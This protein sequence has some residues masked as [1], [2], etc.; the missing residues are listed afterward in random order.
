MSCINE[1]NVVEEHHIDDTLNLTDDIVIG[2]K[3]RNPYSIE[4]MKEACDLMYPPTRGEPPV[5]DSLIVPNIKYVRFLP[6]DS[7]EYRILSN[8]GYELFNYPLD[9]DIL[10][11][12]SDYH[13]PNL[14]PEQI[15]WQY[16]VMPIE[17]PLPISNAEVLELGFL[18]DPTDNSNDLYDLEGIENTAN[19]LVLEEFTNGLRDGYGGGSSASNNS[20]SN[21]PRIAVFDHYSQSTKGVKGIKVRARHFLKIRTAYTD[22]LGYYSINLDGIGSYHPRYE[23]RFENKYGFKIG[24]GVQLIMPITANMEDQNRVTYIYSANYKFWASCIINNAAYDWYKRCE[25][26]GMPTPPND[27]YIWAMEMAGGAACPMFHHKTLQKSGLSIPAIVG[28]YFGFDNDMINFNLL[29]RILELVAP[30][31]VIFGVDESSVEELY[32]RTCHE[33]SHAT[34][35]QRVGSNVDERALWWCDVIQYEVACGIIDSP[36][37]AT[38]VPHSGKVGVTEMWAHAVGH[39][40]QYE[41]QNKNVGAFLYNYWFKPEVIL[42]LYGSGLTLQEIN[43]SMTSEICSLQDFKEQLIEDNSTCDSLI[44]GVFNNRLNL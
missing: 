35:F 36:Y 12:P 42:D 9:Y 38:G 19:S 39:I 32:R 37:E 26:E 14:P 5:S 21:A 1:L 33:L 11:D 13:D 30:D 23:L 2:K 27:L 34:H 31:V 4:V 41:Y 29:N 28:Q 43:Q 20:S 6:T 18:P 16:T 7:T 24:Y 22:S 10:G 3:L 40:C 17:D 25:K 44:R 8:S 15:T